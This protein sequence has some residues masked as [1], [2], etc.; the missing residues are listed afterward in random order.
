MLF[1]VSQVD[2]DRGGNDGADLEVAVT[3]AEGHKCPRCWRTV[4]SIS[5]Q[6]GVEGLCE[7]CIDALAGA[8]SRLA[9]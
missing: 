7:R 6:P 5:S 9:G 1:I 4:A 3:R 8:S 2:L